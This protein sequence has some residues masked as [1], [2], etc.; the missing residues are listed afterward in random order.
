[1]RKILIYI[2]AIVTFGGFLVSCDNGFDELNTNRVQPTSLSPTYLLNT[3]I[4]RSSFPGQ[5]LPY[6]LAIVQQIVSPNS[7]VLAGGNFNQDNRAVTLGV[8]QRY[9]RDVLKHTAD[10][11]MATSKDASKAN[12][13]HMA[14]IIRAH[15]A[16]IVTDTYGDVP[17]TDA[18]Q[19]FITN[20]VLPKY[21]S[22]E[23]IYADILKQLDEASAALD[24]SLP[25]EA[26]EVLY[27]GNIARW[28][29]FGYSLLLRAAMRHSKVA[30]ATA[31]NYAG[32]A[33]AGGLM[34][35]NA[36]NAVIVHTPNYT[37]DIGT[38]LNSTEANNFYLTEPFVNYL[39]NN[40]DPRLASIAV[41]YVGA[42]SGAD[43]KPRT[44][45]DPGNGNTSVAVQIGMPMGYD[46]ASITPV[47]TSKGLASFYDFSQLDRTRMGR[48]DAPA[49][50][51]TYAQTQLLL[52]EAVVRGWAQGDAAT[53]YSNGIRA[54]MQQLS[55]YQNAAVPE[56]AITTYL[57]ANPLDPVNALEQI[58]TQ[59]W[60]A[61]FLNGPEAFANFRRSGFPNLAPNPYPGKDE[62]VVFIRRLTYPDSEKSVNSG[63]IQEAINR[64]GTDDLKTRVWWDK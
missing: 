11:M 34:Q 21:E 40:N 22:Q 64:Q 38:T 26:G 19:G 14:R 50:L 27:G 24:P 36:D 62:G 29:R 23:A 48:V 3:A 47:A 45:T 57:R 30:P 61:S 53:L 56:D 8:W 46:N 13:Y 32:R 25:A 39:K 37:N 51:V 58:N 4:I 54:H 63:N 20:N 2:V 44:A 31:Q 7:G 9:Y 35:S 16:M 10:V 6:E 1:M 5:T 49:F 12:L 33:V 42:K 17:Y 41:R 55:S 52:A 60:V 28:K 15:A 43:Q 18:G 59:Y